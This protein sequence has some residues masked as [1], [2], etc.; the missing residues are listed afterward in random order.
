M[1]LETEQAR[2]AVLMARAAALNARVAAMVAEN[3]HREACGQSIAY[4]EEAFQNTLDLSG[5][6]WNGIANLMI[7]GI[8]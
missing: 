7:H 8:L 2:A 4:G 1:S 5:C 3:Q 6:D